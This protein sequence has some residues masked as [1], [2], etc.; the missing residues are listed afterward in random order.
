MSDLRQLRHFVALADHG[1]FA[2][3]AAAVNLSQP[4][5]SRSIQALEGH[6]DCQL[7]DR[8]PRGVALTAH[9]R[10]VLEHARRLLAAS[11]ALDNAVLQ[12]AS[13]E[14]GELRLGAGPFPAARLM[15]QAL[16]KFSCSY[17]QVTVQ[18]AIENWQSLRQRLLDG[19]I[20]LFIADGR[21]LEGDPQLEVQPLQKHQGVLFCRP[22]HPLC[23]LRNV[24][25]DELRPYPLAGPRLP[26]E[27]QQWLATTL[28]RPQPL[29]VQCDD[30]LLLKQLVASSNAVCLVPWDV[31][32]DDVQS[33]RM[34]I[35]DWN[36]RPTLTSPK[37]SAYAL[38]RLAG[39]SLSPAAQ[40]F[41]DYLLE[42]DG[43]ALPGVQASDGL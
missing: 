22:G 2:R 35:V 30:V 11:R 41:V 7:V 39:R 13:L 26:Q 19:D 32:A 21:E 27:V 1:H 15:P 6:L 36:V 4:A 23:E 24:G 16:G 18:L 5:L 33:G 17:P 38:V 10:L 28:G 34:A 42:I 25:P 8:N 9:G 37:A 31:I 12:L 14:T 40:A 3:A 43:D 20:E 29:G